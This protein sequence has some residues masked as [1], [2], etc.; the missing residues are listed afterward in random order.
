MSKIR[1][2]DP[3][4]CGSGKKYKRCCGK[5]SSRDQQATG[6]TTEALAQAKLIFARREA[7]EHQRRRMQ[8][9]GRP[10][11]SFESNGYRVV[12]IGKQLRWSKS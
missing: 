10:I 12:A 7:H 6:P 8:G 9:L 4:P 5:A 3:C 2:N 1:R 11:I